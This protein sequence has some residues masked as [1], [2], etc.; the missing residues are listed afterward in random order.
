MIV[1][2]SP[3]QQ[4]IRLEIIHFLGTESIWKNYHVTLNNIENQSLSEIQIKIFIL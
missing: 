3:V 2:F 4:K 1:E